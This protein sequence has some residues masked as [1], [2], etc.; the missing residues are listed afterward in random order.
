[1]NFRLSW[2]IF[3]KSNS[4]L[5]L[6]LM[7]LMLFRTLWLAPFELVWGYRVII[8]PK[9]PQ[10]WLSMN[11]HSFTLFSSVKFLQARKSCFIF[12]RIFFAEKALAY[13]SVKLSLRRWLKA[14]EVTTSTTD[15]IQSA[16]LLLNCI[17]S[18]PS[19]C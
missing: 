1:M 16:T 7:C 4:S 18:F 3:R 11:S 14:T 9:A 6:L 8:A 12:P 17:K 5:A 13:P 2:C 19:P 15:I 10:S